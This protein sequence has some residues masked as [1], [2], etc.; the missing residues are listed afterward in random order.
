MHQG[1]GLHG[2]SVAVPQLSIQGGLSNEGSKPLW[3]IPL[4]AKAA[5]G[6]S[7]N[8]AG[9]VQGHIITHGC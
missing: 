2:L 4:V 6:S 7:K 1:Q 8:V 5:V 9:E 3:Y